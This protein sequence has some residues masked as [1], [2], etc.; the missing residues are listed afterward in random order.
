MEA[1]HPMHAAAWWRRCRANVHTWIRRRVGIEP[2]DRPGEELEGVGDATRDCPPNEIWVVPMEVM[3]VHDVSAED[4]IFEAGRE[5]LDLALD[6][7]GHVHRGTARNVAVRVPGVL[8]F[9]R[10]A[11]VEL[12]LLAEQHVR[13]LGMLPPKH[14]GF[15]GCDLLECATEVDRRCLQAVGVTPWNRP[16]E[17]PVELEGAGTIP[18]ATESPPVAARKRGLRQSKRAGPDW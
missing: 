16:V 15:S 10:P 2:R 17:R 12:A 1:A 18:I 3:R 9:G 8:P 4:S 11:L 6:R 5:S 13:P 7:F 14:R